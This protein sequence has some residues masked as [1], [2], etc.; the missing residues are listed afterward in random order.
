MNSTK[1]RSCHPRFRGGTDVSAQKMTSDPKQCEYG[2]F[3]HTLLTL[4]PTG[5]DRWFAKAHRKTSFDF[6]IKVRSK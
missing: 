5:V 1:S 2:D 3:S 4:A 6:F